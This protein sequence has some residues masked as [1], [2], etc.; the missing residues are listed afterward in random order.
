MGSIDAT[1]WSYPTLIAVVLVVVRSD[2]QLWLYLKAHEV[3][4]GK[5]FEQAIKATLEGGPTKGGGGIPIAEIPLG[6][7]TRAA[8]GERAVFDRLS[9]ELQM[10]LLRDRALQP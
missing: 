10:L 3:M 7:A 9:P 8:T 1:A 4:D 6:P 2:S 5:Q